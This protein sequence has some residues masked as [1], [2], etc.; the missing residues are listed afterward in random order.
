M[1][2]S[3]SSGSEGDRASPQKPPNNA[4][5]APIELSRKAEE[6]PAASTFAPGELRL[7]RAVER[8]GPLIDLERRAKFRR[9]VGMTL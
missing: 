9:P 1:F 2:N 3:H 4:A 6:L 5:T 7:R 8:R